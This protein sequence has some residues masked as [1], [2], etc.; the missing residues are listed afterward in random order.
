LSILL[1]KPR[2]FVVGEMER[3]GGGGGGDDEVEVEVEVEVRRK[4]HSHSVNCSRYIAIGN[5][6]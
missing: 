3:G 2:Y 6:K 5:R 4:C 1:K